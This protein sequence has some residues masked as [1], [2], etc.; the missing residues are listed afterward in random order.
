V[1]ADAV[2]LVRDNSGET[3][4]EEKQFEYKYDANGNLIEMTDGS[5]GAE[6]D[7]YK[8]SYT[9]LNQIQKV[10][11]IKDGTTKHTTTY[12]YDANGNPVKRTHDGKED[13]YEYTERNE[14]AKVTNK[15]SSSD[16]DPDVTTFT[17]T[18]N[19]WRQQQTKPNGNTVDY[20]YYLDG[21]LKHQV[22]K[23]S[24]GTIV[25]EHTLKYNANGHRTE[26]VIKELKANSA[27]DY[28]N[29]TMLYEYDPRDRITKVTKKDTATGNVL[30]TET[31]RHDANGNVIEQTLDGITTTYTYDRNRLLS[32]T[33]GG[34]TAKYNY[35]PFGRLNTV[36]ANGMQL[37]KY[38]YDGFDRIAEHKRLED[39]GNT[40][41][42]TKYT[43][44]PLDRTASRTEK[45]GTSNEKTTNFQYLGL[46]DD[47]ISE[48]NDLTD[49]IQKSY[50]YSPWGERLSQ[51]KHGSSAEQSF[52]SYNPHTD[53]EALTDENGTP[54]ATYGYTAYGKLDEESTTGKDDPR[55]PNYNPDD[56]YNVYRFNNKRWDPHT[57]KVDMG[58]RDYDPGLNRF[59]TRDMYNDALSDM[60]L[61]LD[62]WNMNR[63][64]F[65]GG[66]P[67]SFVELD[68]HRYIVAD[69][70]DAP[71]STGRV[72][73]DY[74]WRDHIETEKIKRIQ[75][76][77]QQGSILLDA[78]DE[79]AE[80]LAGDIYT[81]LT[82]KDFLT[83]EKVSDEERKIS[84]IFSLPWGKILK[85]IGHGVKGGAE[86][87][88]DLLGFAGKSRSVLG[89]D[90][91]DAAKKGDVYREWTVTKNGEKIELEA[92]FEVRIEKGNQLWIKDVALYPRGIEHVKN[93]IGPSEFKSLLRQLQEDARNQGFSSLRVSWKR[94]QNSTS[95]NPG[96]IFDRT[97][98]FE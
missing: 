97:W 34:T 49:E 6:I 3:D 15:E 95:A 74:A 52:Y 68:G 43:Y 96:Q 46:T 32:A 44:D 20:A 64:A 67:I 19:G 56:P 83:E 35:D 54:V 55:D 92:L 84:V 93:Q 45:A 73:W 98:Y 22:E 14:L 58:F 18:P 23:K 60:Q 17:Y 42:T 65:A 78:Y 1:I 66:N 91:R 79:I 2:K 48:T 30:E 7:T 12:E 81:S 89:V 80:F 26:D 57:G 39:D 24:N 86:L 28:L 4:N 25:N 29:H 40:S 51:I 61:T 41:T 13:L 88:G 36:T 94:E 87:A 9:E 82:G 27:S 76:Q 16:S 50:T 62:P 85:V 72:S 69:G 31:Y 5:S 21:L 70:V 77:E 47:V 33:S 8:M 90:F 38:T 37:E 11:E 53:V 75:K 59:L 71:S 63:Y 10:E